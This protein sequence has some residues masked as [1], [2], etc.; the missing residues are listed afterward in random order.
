MNWSI[1]QSSHDTSAFSTCFNVAGKY[2]IKGR[3]EDAIGC[4][5]T[6]TYLVNAYPNP[7]ADFN[8][9][10]DTPVENGDD[11]QFLNTSTGAEITA[12]NWYFDSKPGNE[13]SSE[14]PFYQFKEEGIYPVTLVIK[15]NAG[16]SDTV[17]KA[18]HVDPDFAFYVPNAFTP[19]ADGKNELLIPVTRGIKFFSLNVFDRWGKKI[20]ELTD[21]GNGWD[22]TYNGN[23]CKQDV[24]VWKASVSAI[25][26]Q[27]MTFSGHVTLLR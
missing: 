21:A 18:I 4:V 7:V 13:S 5:N 19:N 9:K 3:I 24:Y 15:T 10:P 8:Y 6:Q 26:G 25:N 12:F 17:T 11:V 2:L 16:C 20:I 14:N 22:G 27:V 1:A 23:N